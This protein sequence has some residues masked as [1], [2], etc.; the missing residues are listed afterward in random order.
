MGA[1]C[2][3]IIDKDTHSHVLL[4][5]I[6]P[7][8]SE[9]ITYNILVRFQ[10]GAQASD[11]NWFVTRSFRWPDWHPFESSPCRGRCK[12]VPASKGVVG[13]SW[14]YILSNCKHSQSSSYDSLGGAGL[15]TLLAGRQRN[16]DRSLAPP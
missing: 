8:V 16:S 7:G 11:D 15:T 6:P 9:W 3:Y 2:E 1:L 14:V 13:D 10:S 5:M 4:P 12:A